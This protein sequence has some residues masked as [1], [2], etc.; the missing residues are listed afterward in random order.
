MVKLVE[1]RSSSPA[2]ISDSDDDEVQN[3]G[4][5]D[6]GETKRKRSVERFFDFQIQMMILPQLPSWITM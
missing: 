6:G 2:V 4:R 3:T 1:G 5:E